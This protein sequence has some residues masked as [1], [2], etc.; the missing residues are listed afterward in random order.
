MSTKS[1]T[2]EIQ[3]LVGV[4]VDGIWGPGTAKAV[5]EVL[6]ST[7]RLTTP[8][9]APAEAKYMFEDLYPGDLITAQ[10]HDI[11]VQVLNVFET[12]TKEGDYSNVSIYADGPGGVKQ[13]TYGKSQ[14]TESGNLKSLLQTYLES[15]PQTEAAGIIKDRVSRVGKLPYMVQDKEFINALKAAGKETLMKEAQDSFFDAVYFNPAYKWFHE[16]GFTLPL[17]LLVI[18]DSFIHSGSI[19]AFLRKRFSEVPPTNGGDEKAWIKAYVKT[20][21]SWLTNHTN[22]VLRNTVYRMETMEKAISSDNWLLTQPVY[23][24]GVTVA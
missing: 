11:C 14:T 1:D 7:D 15:N 9:Q 5:L 24:N 6:R 23:A 13:I 3:K 18:Y 16:N 2:Q 22:K 10:V 19:L 21:K 12:G 17:S 20:R 8:K 4:T